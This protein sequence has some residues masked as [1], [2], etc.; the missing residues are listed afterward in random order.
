MDHHCPWI[1]NCVGHFNYKFFFLMVFYGAL[2]LNIFTWTFWETVHVWVNDPDATA[3]A[4][5]FI[6]LMYSLVAMLAIVVTA[7]L[8]FHFYL[9]TK[10]FSTIEY[11]EKKRSGSKQFADSP[12]KIST[13]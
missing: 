1:A 10:N 9:I 5:F 7:F 4:C 13:G 3:Y 2:S 12:F 11:C 8:C 6:V